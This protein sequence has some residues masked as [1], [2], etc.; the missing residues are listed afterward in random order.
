GQFRMREGF[1]INKAYFEKWQSEPSDLR[2]SFAVTTYRHIN[3]RQVVLKQG[4]FQVPDVGICA[5]G[6]VDILYCR[7]AIEGPPLFATLAS[8]GN[9]CEIPVDETPTPEGKL[10][11]DTHWASNDEAISPVETF[12]ISF[13]GWEDMPT[14]EKQKSSP[15]ICPGTQLTLSTIEETGKARIE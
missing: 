3:P 7:S 11:H 2:L 13:S 9:P 14:T 12:R 15:H 8:S 10:S 6:T 1:E 4:E 5:L